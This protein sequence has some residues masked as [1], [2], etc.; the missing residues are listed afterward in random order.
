MSK[1]HGVAICT[2]A[3]LILQV[4]A[5]PSWGAGKSNLP[6]P[7][8]ANVAYGKDPK[9]VFDLWLAKGDGLHPLAVWIHGG[10]FVGGSKGQIPEG[11]LRHALQSGISVAS[12]DYRLSPAVIMP[13]HYLDCGRAVQTLRHRAEEWRLDKERFVCAGS[14]AG[15]GATLWLGFHP[16]LADPASADSVARESTHFVALGGVAAQCSYDPRFIKKLLGLQTAKH[17]ALKTAYGL[18]ETNQDTPEAS[19][20]YEE[21]SAITYATK[22]APPCFLLYGEPDVP[23]HADAKP[24]Q[25][26]HHPAFGKALKEKLDGLGVECTVKIMGKGANREDS[27]AEMFR[28][29]ETKLGMTKTAKD[30]SGGK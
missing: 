29:F 6:A 17:P 1:Q 27:F 23:V 7:D 9:Q 14:S 18:T 24:G 21:A 22:D 19:R 8:F 26:M 2:T 25:G 30:A 5:A 3:F 16:D 12:F 15:G 4:F 20:K 28:F 10:G 11:Y 13:Q